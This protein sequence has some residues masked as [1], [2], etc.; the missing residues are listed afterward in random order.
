MLNSMVFGA[1]P[2]VDNTTD[3]RAWGFRKYHHQGL[4]LLSAA[5]SASSY[6]SRGVYHYCPPRLRMARKEDGTEY[7]HHVPFCSTVSIN[8]LS[9]SIS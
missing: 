3:V 7:N 9:P 6:G 1:Y 8:H 5:D 2:A 4:Q